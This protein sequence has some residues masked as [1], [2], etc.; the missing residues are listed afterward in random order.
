M[1]PSESDRPDDLFFSKDMLAWLS[2][3]GPVLRDRVLA[4]FDARLAHRREMEMAALQA[5]AADTR[6]GQYCGLAVGMTSIIGA[7]VACTLGAGVAG[8]T[9]AG[10][11]MAALAAVSI[12]G[13]S[14]RRPRRPPRGEPAK[15]PTPG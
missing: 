9:I 13:R 6:R 1:S 11:G 15:P 12:F 2:K 5:D 8:A 10:V 4:A 3:A 14:D 7:T